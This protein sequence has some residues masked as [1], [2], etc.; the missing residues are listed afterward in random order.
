MAT[1]SPNKGIAEGQAAKVNALAAT[2][3][4]LVTVATS[5]VVAAAISAAS[6]TAAGG[7]VLGA[8]QLAALA[9]PA[10]APLIGVASKLIAVAAVYIAAW[11][12]KRH[13]LDKTPGVE[14]GPVPGAQTAPLKVEP[15]KSSDF[16]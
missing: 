2:G 7:A 15:R 5:P 14:Q 12:R 16:Q 6:A 3:E 8:G 1:V 10:Y 13:E 4:V 11:L 9:L